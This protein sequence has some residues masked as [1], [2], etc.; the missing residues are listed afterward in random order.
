MR[1]ELKAIIERGGEGLSPLFSKAMAD[2]FIG[3]KSGGRRVTVN[4][5]NP[6]PEGGA[7]SFADGGEDAG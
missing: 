3:P 7:P 1:N 4:P 5:R 6:A 2:Y